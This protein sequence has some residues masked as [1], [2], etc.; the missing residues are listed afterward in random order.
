MPHPDWNESYLSGDA[1]WD[2][3]E[4]DNHLVE[5]VRSGAIAPG[6]ALEVGCGTGT[7]ALWLA[8]QGYVALGIDIAPL[9][10]EQA[11]ANAADS[12]P[13]CRFETLDFLNDTVPG[14]PFDFVFDRGCFHVFDAHE[15]RAGFAG[16]VATLLAPEGRWLSLAGSTE[17]GEREEGPPRLTASEVISAIEPVLEILELRAIEFRAKL[18]EPAAAWF[19]LSRPRRVPAV[20]STWHD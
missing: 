15:N 11:R 7:N 1:P 9:A 17:G 4:P 20:P 6:R 12:K 10:I 2:T 5:F 3:G 18:P 16:R 19:C 14:A 13:D 8:G